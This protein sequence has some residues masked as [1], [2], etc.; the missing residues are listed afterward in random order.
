M[1]A[2]LSST[3]RHFRAQVAAHTRWARTDPAQASAAARARLLLRF[4]LEAEA[5]FGP[6]D[7]LERRRRA[8]H[9]LR[10]HMA[11]LAFRKAALQREAML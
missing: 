6:L 10:A 4:E 3:E 9:L 1:A 8:E 5:Q 7:D 11:K 2:R